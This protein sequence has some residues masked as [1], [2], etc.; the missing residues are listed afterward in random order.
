MPPRRTCSPVELSLGTRPRWAIS[1]RGVS[2]RRTSPI[3]ATKVTAVRKATPRLLGQALQ[4]GLSI[5]DGLPVFAQDQ[6]LGRMLE[7]EVGEPSGMDLGPGP[8]AGIDP[9][10]AQQK[11][12]QM[13]A[14]R[15]QVRHRGLTGPHQLA[16]GLM[17]RVGD[18]DAGEFARAMQ[19]G[20]GDGIPAIGLDALARPLRD[21]RGS[22]DGAVMPEGGDLPLQPIA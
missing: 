16:H 8:G 22:N 18:P 6:I 11:G 19:P 7:A 14:L 21:Q 13:L 1:C 5:V 9:S 3:S 20:Q 15:A 17:P 4:S 12:L 10:V 2:K